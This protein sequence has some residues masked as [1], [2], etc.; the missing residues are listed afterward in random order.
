MFPSI[1]PII[2]PS[3]QSSIHLSTLL[4]IHPVSHSSIHPSAHRFSTHSSIRFSSIHLSNHSISNTCRAYAGNEKPGDR[5]V[6]IHGSK[7]GSV[8]LVT[9][10]EKCPGV[11]K[12]LCPLFAYPGSFVSVPAGRRILYCRLHTTYDVYCR[13]TQ[14][15]LLRKQRKTLVHSIVGEERHL[16]T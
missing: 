12:P 9:M 8:V 1:L 2:H 13:G 3:S 7:G 14:H 6:G 10:G 16:T 11:M 15:R 5:P 4:Y